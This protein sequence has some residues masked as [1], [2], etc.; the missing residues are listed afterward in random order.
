MKRI[1][2]NSLLIALTVFLAWNCSKD[3]NPLLPNGEEFNRKLEIKTEKSEYYIGEDFYNMAFVR[4]TV[5]NTSSDTFYSKLGD[6]FNASID[7]DVLQIAK[8]TEGYFE[9]NIGDNKW[10]N[11][12]LGILIEG[13]RIIRILPLKEYDL[14]AIAYLD[15]NSVGKFR[16]RVNYYKSYSQPSIDTL[17]DTSNTFFIYRR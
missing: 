8:G 10:E 4:S 14:H 5:L 12:N 15:S 2:V 6:G 3:Q 16:L 9:Q 13:S 7:Q 1:I 11:L 17:R